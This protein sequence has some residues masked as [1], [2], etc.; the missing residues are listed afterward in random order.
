M[1]DVPEVLRKVH[2]GP[3]TLKI[4]HIIQF[5]YLNIFSIWFWYK[6]SFLLFF[7]P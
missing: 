4:S 2:F 3:Q 1:G 5:Q 7:N 6:N